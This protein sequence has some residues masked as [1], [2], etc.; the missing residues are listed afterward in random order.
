MIVHVFAHYHGKKELLWKYAEGTCSPA[1]MTTVEEWLATDPSFQVELDKVI[2][3]HSLL[4]NMEADA[5][6][7]RFT[8]NVSEALPNVYPSVATEPLVSPIWKKVFFGAVAFFAGGV[9]LSSKA[10]HHTGGVIS[11]YIERLNN[12]LSLTVGQIPSIVLQYFILTLL[13]VG[14]LLL[15]DKALMKK[16]R[17]FLLV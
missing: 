3:A 11:Q 13:S 15:M 5:P 16:V 7:L 2:H 9:F 6:S 4:A 1:E 10:A 12:G 17:A 14:L 8:K